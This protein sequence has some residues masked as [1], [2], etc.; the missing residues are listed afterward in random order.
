MTDAGRVWADH[1]EW[2]RYVLFEAAGDYLL[3][4]WVPSPPI[5]HHGAYRALMWWRCCCRRPSRPPEPRRPPAERTGHAV[6]Q[7]DHPPAREAGQQIAR[8]RPR[9]GQGEGVAFTDL[10]G[11][12]RQ[13]VDAVH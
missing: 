5:W 12:G 13:D 1:Q 8:Q 7:K 9:Q 3:L 10:A 11:E 2:A 4:G 6:A